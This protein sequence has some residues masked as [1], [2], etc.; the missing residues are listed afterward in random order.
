MISQST[1][2]IFFRRASLV[3]LLLLLGIAWLLG[4]CT[5]QKNSPSWTE[6]SFFALDTYNTLRVWE[7]EGE[8]VGECVRLVH[9]YEALF[10]RTL[11]DSD[12]GRINRAA[13]RYVTVS[14]QTAELIAIAQHY[15]QLSDGAF[16]ISMGAVSRLW[17]FSNRQQG[18]LPA[19]AAIAD[20]L[21]HVDYRQISIEDRAV[22]I[23]PGMV[24]DVGSIAKGYIADRLADTL[25]TYGYTSA[26][27]D[28]GGNIYALGQRPD[29]QPWRVGI[30]GPFE[31]RNQSVAVL[32]VENAS[33]VTSAIY[34]R[35]FMLD[36]I[37]YHHL[38]SPV[39]GY[40]ARTGIE[41]VSIIAPRSVD[42][43]ALSTCLFVLGV[44]RGQALI[45]SLPDTEAIIIPDHG[46]ALLSSGLQRGDIPI[47]WNNKQLAP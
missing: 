42:A 39:D 12:I 21:S 14:P 11:P 38:L 17:D 4:G 37:L 24:L 41:A 43:D 13:G 29:G 26:M 40:P 45:E 2:S 15:S 1:R 22:R 6:H 33:V 19:P 34:E 8:H 5:K 31:Q 7:G 10:S 30:Q 25:R 28:L 20:A 9:A 3:L 16:D 47:H 36:D 18:Q 46:K 35:Y 27:I 32:S 23:Q 44:E